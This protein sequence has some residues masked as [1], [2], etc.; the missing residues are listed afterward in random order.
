[1]TV[2]DAPAFCAWFNR[3]ATEAAIA[4]AAKELIVVILGD[5]ILPKTA[6][7]FM[8]TPSLTLVHPTVAAYRVAGLP[9]C[10][11]KR[12]PALVAP[13]DSDARTRSHVLFLGSA[14]TAPSRH[15][16]GFRSWNAYLAGFTLGI[17]TRRPWLVV[18][19]SLFPTQLTTMLNLAFH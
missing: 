19:C 18:A 3:T 6:T 11:R 2:V 5:A 15:R 9:H 7:L 4:L 13:P 1:M 8:F 14:C 17:R 10:F 12:R 16:P